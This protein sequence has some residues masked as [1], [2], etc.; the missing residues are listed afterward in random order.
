MLA[1][2]CRH[3]WTGRLKDPLLLF[4]GAT[5]DVLPHALGYAVVI[6]GGGSFTFILSIAEMKKLLAGKSV[7]VDST[8][9]EANAAMKS[10]VRRDTGDNW[11]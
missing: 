11:K 10:I 5:P 8:L 9:I 4:G 6:L 1:D 2:G 7:A 3:T